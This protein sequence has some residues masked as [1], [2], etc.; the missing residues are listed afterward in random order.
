[1]LLVGTVA[2]FA[3]CPYLFPSLGPTAFLQAEYP[4]QRSSGIYHVVVG[5]LLGL[6]SGFLA[7]GLSGA[8]NVAPASPGAPI[9][10]ARALA[11]LFAVAITI[12]LQ[13]AA[14]ASHPPAISTSLLIALGAF[15]ASLHT[16]ATI[17][18]GVLLV[19]VPGELLRQA[20]SR[21]RARQ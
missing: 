16:V 4:D 5:H 19:G 21:A 8:M 13:L 11:V 3:R 20:R 14:R 12:L 6:V 17:T 2:L 10:L 1:M 9:T 18:T 7:V 15:S